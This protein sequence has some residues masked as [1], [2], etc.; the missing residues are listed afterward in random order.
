MIKTINQIPK[1][2]RAD[3]IARGT[4]AANRRNDVMAKHIESGIIDRVSAEEMA[5]NLFNER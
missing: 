3:F 4:R 2:V 5:V 1:S